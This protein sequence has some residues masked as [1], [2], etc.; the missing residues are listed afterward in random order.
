MHTVGVE[1]AAPGVLVAADVA[2]AVAVEVRATVAVLEG[3]PGVEVEVEAGGVEVAGIAVLLE[4]GN[5]V[6]VTPG[7]VVAKETS[8]ILLMK[9][10][11][12]AALLA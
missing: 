5:E 7:V 11:N 2:T 6:V 10:S 3:W 4:V 1:V 12:G 9:R 8:E